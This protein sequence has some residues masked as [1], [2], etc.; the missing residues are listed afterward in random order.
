MGQL[1]TGE[2]LSGIKIFRALLMMSSSIFGAEQRSGEL[3]TALAV[4]TGPD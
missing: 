2:S 3:L 4:L 1:N